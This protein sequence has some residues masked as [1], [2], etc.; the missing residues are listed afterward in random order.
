MGY[1]TAA[2]IDGS[3]YKLAGALYGTCT[4]AESTAAKVVT[5]TDFDELVT[6]VTIPVKFSNANSG[7]TLNVTLN[8][9][10]TGAKPVVGRLGTSSAG[11][12]ITWAAGSVVSFTY[13][14]DYW[15][16]ND[17]YWLNNDTKNTAGA[18]NN[19][20]DPLYLIGATSQ[21]A[22]PQTYSNSKLY[23]TD[24][25][26][27]A[28]SYNGVGM[29][30]PS[31]GGF[32]L[33][34]TAGVATVLKVPPG[35]DYDLAAACEKGVDTSIASGST[36]TNLPTTAAVRAYVDQV[37]GAAAAGALVYQGTVGTGGD[38]ADLPAAHTKG[39]YYVVK[40]A[41]TFAGVSCEAGDMI[42][43][44]NTGTTASDADWDVIQA[45][46]V[47]LTTAEIDADWA[48]A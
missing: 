27:V 20:T 34:S 35:A 29:R 18:T 23:A 14:G 6:G 46:I 36:S 8:V 45:N 42:I 1:L 11:T 16:M 32:E 13:D 44:K 26:L 39:W 24:G 3:G 31:G 22:N 21:G 7:G 5:C 38:I 47:A 40:A 4:T 25:D 15:C 37:A 33:Q 12:G 19:S 28:D 10:S 9:N 2:N 43:C 30:Q 17:S 48:A 41:G